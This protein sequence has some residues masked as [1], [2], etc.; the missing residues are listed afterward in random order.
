MRACHF[1]LILKRPQSKYFRNSHR[2]CGFLCNRAHIVVFRLQ[3]L[4]RVYGSALK[5][6]L[7]LMDPN[8]LDLCVQKEIPLVDVLLDQSLL[9]NANPQFV[10]A[11]AKGAYCAVED[12][13]AH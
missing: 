4:I 2:V 1:Y 9:L 10:S 3:K 6:F 13:L 11:I 8:D 7:N 12:Q 5:D